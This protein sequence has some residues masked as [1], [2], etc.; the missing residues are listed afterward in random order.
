MVRR[1]AGQLAAGGRSVIKDFI[2]PKRNSTA[3]AAV[4][5]T[6]GDS[7]EENPWFDPG[8]SVRRSES[9]SGT[10]L[11]HR[12][13]YDLGSGVIMLP[14]T[15]DWLGD[16]VDEG[17]DDNYGSVI[18]DD[19]SSGA[20]ESEEPSMNNAAE[21]GHQSDTAPLA[22]PSTIARSRYGT[23]FHHPERRRQTIPGAF[24]S[25]Q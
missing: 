3:P 12:L 19:D 24:P 22:R 16:D 5:S 15:A 7:V 21:G 2:G 18:D 9:V 1:G 4:E 10:T 25:S 14:E 6:R 20:H 17:S 11:S 8:S 23:Y 13:S